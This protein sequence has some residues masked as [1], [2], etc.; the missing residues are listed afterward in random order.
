M[1]VVKQLVRRI[2]SDHESM[3]SVDNRE[4]AWTALPECGPGVDRARISLLVAWGMPG[5]LG[6]VLSAL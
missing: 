4:K 5:E 3:A 2:Y 6:E 1:P